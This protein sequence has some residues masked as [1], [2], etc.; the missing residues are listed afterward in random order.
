MKNGARF[1]HQLKWDLKYV[2][3]AFA[4]LLLVAPV[5]VWFE[6]KEFKGSWG[7]FRRELSVAVWVLMLLVAVVGLIA[8]IQK[9]V[10]FGS[11]EFW[12]SRPVGRGVLLMS[13][14]T[15]LVLFST[16]LGLTTMVAPFL[17]GGRWILFGLGFLLWWGWALVL[18]AV[19]ASLSSGWVRLLMN[20]V[21]SAFL[22]VAAIVLHQ[23]LVPRVN[24][25][26]FAS[27]NFR[28]V[29]ENFQIGGVGLVVLV[30]GGV[31]LIVLIWQFLIPHPRWGMAFFGAVLV[32][33]LLLLFENR[34]FGG[35][36]R[37]A[38]FNFQK[39]ARGQVLLD[40]QWPKEKSVLLQKEGKDG[41]VFTFL[42]YGFRVEKTFP[43]GFVETVR[44]KGSWV[45][46]GRAI[47]EAKWSGAK[48]PL[49]SLEPSVLKEF[50]DFSEDASR[51]LSEDDI[52]ENYWHGGM[53]HWLQEEE[54]A[55]WRESRLGYQGEAWISVGEYLPLD[56]FPFGEEQLVQSQGLHLR[57]GAPAENR[58]WGELSFSIEWMK[59]EPSPFDDTN[60]Q[61]RFDFFVVH[62]EGK[63]FVRFSARIDGYR[64]HRRRFGSDDFRM[65][66]G[67]G[68]A[69][70]GKTFG[71]LAE[72]D[73]WLEG[74][75][76]QVYLRKQK[77]LV[78][79]TVEL[80]AVSFEE[81]LKSIERS[82][83][84]EVFR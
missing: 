5:E 13:K 19:L 54:L 50:Q 74:C 51:E 61:E 2:W 70:G 53:A 59:W 4:V 32:G 20:A 82:G 44:L 31:G 15:I 11:G 78:M 47:G 43:L 18:A 83:N 36:V 17:T 81:L 73:D 75:E 62:P 26:R 24:D 27:E 65:T 69:I 12:R 68:L 29:N 40:L 35:F 45:V 58:D 52:E 16:V 72:R 25:Y 49:V 22:V 41:E 10:P 9:D 42:R 8:V 66:S 64:D 57:I 23:V 84:V 28:I 55:D 63:E 77:G 33:G 37:L 3:W 38:H 48:A 14:L 34:E 80:E 67:G 7:A 56:R 30:A 79:Q 71:S 76:M 60:E 39:E 21:I 1:W 46:D 6:L